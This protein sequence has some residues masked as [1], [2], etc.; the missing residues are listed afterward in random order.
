MIFRVSKAAQRRAHHYCVWWAR[1][2]LPA[3]RYVF[4]IFTL[5]FS[6][7][8]FSLE[9]LTV[10]L[11]WFPNP[12]HAPLFV[13]QQEGFFK[14]QGLEVDLIGPAN[15]SDPPKLVAANKADIG[16]TY[17]YELALDQ[18]AGLP[19][20]QIGTLINSSLGCLAV[21][22]KSNI[23]N[24]K[25][26]KGKTI[27][28]SSADVDID[29]LETM[30]HSVGLT[31]KDVTLINVNYDLT[32]ALMTHRVDAIT[33]IMRNFEV[34]QLE[35]NH[36]PVRV[37]YPEKYGVPVYPELIFITN[38][39]NLNNPKFIRFFKA[40]KEGNEYLQKNPEKSWVKFSQ[41][42]PELNN[43]LNGRAWFATLP[44]F[45]STHPNSSSTN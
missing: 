27:A 25:D 22:A 44:Y 29:I 30:L 12:N 2:A 39:N 10:I 1:F 21:S 41:N 3:I 13:A 8:T 7:L 45:F 16:V 36:F 42:H 35:L 34:I 24:L 38:K 20:I 4:F 5:L 28:Y 26:L 9:K 19:L 6:S 33:G 11:D 18:K 17:G 31:L 43:E 23:N 32:Q 15:P 37:F 40:L 14:Q